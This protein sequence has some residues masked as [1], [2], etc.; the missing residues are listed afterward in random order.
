MRNLALDFL[1]RDGRSV[2]PDIATSGSSSVMR[3]V[4]FGLGFAILPSWCINTEDN[5]LQQISLHQLPQV[6]VYFGEAQYL[7]ESVYV[8][9]LFDNFSAQIEANPHFD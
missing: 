1:N 2:S 5:R 4:E 3:C 7:R 6:K 8:Q 9:A